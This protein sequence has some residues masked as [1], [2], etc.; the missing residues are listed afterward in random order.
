[1]HPRE[2]TG[3]TWLGLLLGL[4]L[5]TGCATRGPNHVY[6]TAAASPAVHDLG[7]SPAKIA[8]VVKS[9]EQALGLA[10]DFNT[11]HLFVR[12]APA[13]VIR[14]IERPSGKILRD[15]PLPAALQTTASADL[16]IRS[17]DRH[18]FAVHPDGRSVVELT[19]YGET[20]RR[21]ELPGLAGPIHGLAY[22]QRG[23]RL[24][25]LSAAR[26]RVQ[27]G[28][29]TPEGNVTY[30]VT[31][32]AAVSPVSLGYDSDAQHYFVPL[33]DGRS[34]GEFDAAGNLVATHPTTGAGPITAIDAGPRSLVRVF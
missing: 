12:I 19:L 30:Y 4:M 3:T 29:V 2:R 1:M 7:P 13:Q 10:Y 28:A 20:I 17:G 16:A 6:L 33:A 11:D 24:L 18:L 32:A 34:L 26:D 5:S 14:V 21:V 9:G 22:D 25:I 31:L 27:V 23:D 15:M 8:D